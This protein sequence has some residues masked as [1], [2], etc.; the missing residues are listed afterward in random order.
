MPRRRWAMGSGRNA[1][2]R[3]PSALISWRRSL[4]MHR[5]SESIAAIATALAKAQIELSNPEKAMIGTIYNNRSDSPQNFRYASLS[6]G[7]DIIRK[8]LGGP[9]LRFWGA[10]P[11][12]PNGGGPPPRPP[13]RPVLD[14]WNRRRRRSRRPGYR[15]R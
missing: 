4:A 14:G 9:V 3:A 7:L 10:F 6:S 12:P 8:A 2:N 1:R 5:S 11:P 15:Q 13:L